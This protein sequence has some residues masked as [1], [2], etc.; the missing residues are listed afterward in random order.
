MGVPPISTYSST[1]LFNCFRT[2]KT[3]K[4]PEDFEIRFTFTGTEDEKWFYAVSAAIDSLS[5]DIISIISEIAENGADSDLDEIGFRLAAI[6]DEMTRVLNRMYEKCRPEVFYNRI[7][8]Y[9]SGWFNDPNFEETGGLI[10]E[11][12][13]GSVVL[14]LAGGSA[15][16]NPTVQLLDILLDVKHS[17]EPE[18]ATLCNWDAP[19]NCCPVI[20][21]GG[22]RASYLLAMRKYM[23]REHRQYLSEIAKRPLDRQA[24]FKRTAGYAEAIKALTNFRS[25]H[26][27]MVTGYVVCQNSRA[28]GTGGSNP[29]PF[30]KKLR[31]DTIDCICTNK[32]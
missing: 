6:I 9:F 16:Q 29:I 28:M 26:I 14:N 24:A 17:D 22:D 18:Y 2:G 7:R 1:V 10:Y 30:L 15:A 5:R 32:K 3:F 4:R 31:D 8:R 19:L 27:K 20:G 25:E 12:P 11:L 13:D 23:P 21:G